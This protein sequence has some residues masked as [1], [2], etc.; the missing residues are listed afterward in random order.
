MPSTA[1]RPKER[2]TT[3]RSAGARCRSS[4]YKR[5]LR[6]KGRRAKINKNLGLLD[7]KVADAIVQAADEVLAGKHQKEFP[8][9][10]FQTGSGTSTNMNVNEVLA[11]LASKL[12][13]QKISANDHVNMSQSSNDVIPTAIHLSAIFA[14]EKKLLP[15][16]DKLIKSL[17]TRENELKLLAKTGRTHLMDAMPITFGQE[18]SGWRTQIEHS[19]HRIQEALHF[20]RK[21]PLGGTAVG[22]GINAHPDFAANFAT[23][24]SKEKGTALSKSDNFLKL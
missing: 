19:K 22:T 10:I 6:L 16:L 4:S 15:A 12:S 8:I 5:L 24:L 9:D 14:V 7:S 18:I 21:L 1:H 3:F 20:L 17:Q 13:D 2:S 23:L 11:S